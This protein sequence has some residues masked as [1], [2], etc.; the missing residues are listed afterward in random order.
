M[1]R[2]RERRYHHREDFITLLKLLILGPTNIPCIIWGTYV[3]DVPYV[4]WQFFITFHCNP[5]LPPNFC[6]LWLISKELQNKTGII[7]IYKKRLFLF[8]FKIFIFF[9]TRL[10]KTS[11][12]LI[13]FFAWIWPLSKSRTFQNQFVQNIRDEDKD[14]KTHQISPIWSARHV[15]SF[16]AGSLFQLSCVS[17]LRSVQFHV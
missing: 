5:R 7:A 11:L 4:T 2:Y 9:K 17:Q 15:I 12:F 3:Q 1:Y 10:Y 16:V 6:M 8:L 13:C 14:M